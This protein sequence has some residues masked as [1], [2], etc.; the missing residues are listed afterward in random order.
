MKVLYLGHYREGTGWAQAAID[1]ILAMDSV[2]IDVAC[3]NISLTGNHGEVPSRIAE[4]EEKDYTDAEVCIQHLLPHHLVGSGKFKKNI[5]LFVSET[6]SVK[7]TPWFLQLEQMDEIWVPN[8]GLWDTLSRDNIGSQVRV[9]PHAF[10]LDKYS[11]KYPAMSNAGTDGTFKFYYIGDI[12]QRKNIEGILKC[13]HSEF[14]PSE[15]ASLILKVSKFGL[16]SQEVHKLIDQISQKVK[17]ELRMYDNPASYKMEAVLSER[18]PEED[19]YALHSYCDCFICPSHGEA[20]SIPSFDAM[21]FGNTP[22]CSSFGGPKDFVDTDNKQTGWAV[23]GT[24]AVC[25]CHDAAF[26]EIFTGR[27]TWF[28]PDESE[29]KKAMRYY[30]ENQFDSQ[31]G[32][33]RANKFS[34]ESIGNMIKE[35][36]S[37]TGS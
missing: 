4:L 28:S 20:W 27:E 5:A 11:K 6:T 22:I 8:E 19:I 17:H 36:I 35:F 12:N 21:A 25:T 37:D 26:R 18:I 32:L 14:D 24:N 33:D 34:Y 3:R 30:Y 9:V 1:Y 23:G 10:N 15:P 29:I 7:T 16:N 2:G 31:D 13:F